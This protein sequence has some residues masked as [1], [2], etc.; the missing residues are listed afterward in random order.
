MTG[1]MLS[2]PPGAVPFGVPEIRDHQPA[3]LGKGAAAVGGP[4]VTREQAVS[5]YKACVLPL[6]RYEY[7]QDRVPDYPAR[8]EA[9]LNFVDDLI[10]C[11]KAPKAADGW[12]APL[13]CIAP[14]ER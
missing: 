8:V 10:Q 6:V 4:M 3:K 5:S 14:W 7:E 9:W 13:C 12:A 2:I 11:R 1:I